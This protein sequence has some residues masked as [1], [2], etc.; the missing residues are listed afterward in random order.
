MKSLLSS[1]IWLLVIILL[2]IVLC[3]AIVVQ[4]FKSECVAAKAIFD[5]ISEWAI[6]LGAVATL[7]LAFAAFWSVNKSIEHEK[8]IRDENQE[9]E[10]KRRAIRDVIQWLQ[11]VMSSLTLSGDV[12]QTAFTSTM[13]VLRVKLVTLVNTGDFAMEAAGIF[14]SDFQANIRKV[15]K[16]LWRSVAQNLQGEGEELSDKAKEALVQLSSSVRNAIK[17]AYR[18]KSEHK[19]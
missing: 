4:I 17:E 2:A 12:S 5:F 15:I 3:L 11:D 18:L 1:R 14:A 8:R 9:V 16:D 7:V 13:L 6:A 10:F 19:L